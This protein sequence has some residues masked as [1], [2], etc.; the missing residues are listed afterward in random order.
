MA[1][2]A[3]AVWFEAA[4]S[5]AVRRESLPDV[6][7]SD[8]RVRSLYSGIS[9]GTEMLVYR[10]EVPA[11]TALDLPTLEGSFGFPVKYGY[12]GVGCVAEVG[13]E[14]TAVRVGDR[15]FVHHPH[16]SEYVVPA[17]LAVPLPADLDPALGVFFANVETALNVVLDAHPHLGDSAAVFGQGVVG[18]L[19]TQL[20]RRAG[21]SSVVTIDPSAARRCLSLRVGADSSVG[22]ESAA[23]LIRDIAAGR[24][25]DLAIEA[26]GNPA[27]LGAALDAVGV[28][29]TVVVASWYGTKPVSL[30]LGDRFHRDRLRLVSSQ[31]GKLSPA[32]GPGWDRGRRTRLSVGLLS[33]LTLDPL[34]THRFALRSAPEAYRLV[35]RCPGD[36]GQVIFTYG[37]GNV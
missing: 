1:G 8:I 23:E 18:L 13:G 26:S 29:G 3:E 4:R 6:G 2:I 37:E 22:P 12:A 28:E 5:A 11:D 15:V 10:G 20:L 36:T 32:L 21:V 30:P 25:T 19:V 14:V 7:P 24:G 34:F 16:Q 31:V 17:K 9:Q 33:Q 35:D 27:A